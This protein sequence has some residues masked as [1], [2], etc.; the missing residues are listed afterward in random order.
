MQN[1]FVGGIGDYMKLG[2]LRALSP[3]YRLGV[4]W[5]LFPDESDNQ[6]G[7]RI[8]YLNRQEVWWHFDPPLF[9]ALDDIVST[10]QRDVRAL[11]RANI[12]PGAI[13][14]RDV[15]P[16]DGPIARRTKARVEWF[17]N[18]QGVL[19]G[20]DLVFVDPD[21][22]LESGGYKHGW[23]KSGKSI[24]LNELRQLARPGR[25]LIVY[26]HHTPRKGD[27]LS[28]VEHWTYRLRRCGF[29]TVD[30]LR[31]RPVSPRAFFLLEAPTDILQRAERIAANWEGLITWHP[32]RRT[33]AD[34]T[35]NDQS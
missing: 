8:G 11:E 9:D 35:V 7:G 5:W 14:A 17:G 21:Y 25:C 32:D 19:E 4:A 1:R 30:V 23:S 22:G 33:G 16:V 10:C 15:I 31:T 26:H 2:I 27:K 34:L 18:V 3:G 28:E 24:L 6:D 13:F 12:L 20:A 29:R